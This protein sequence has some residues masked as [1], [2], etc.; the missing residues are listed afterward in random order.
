MKQYKRIYV[1][2]LMQVMGY[3]FLLNAASWAA[4][5]KVPA[6]LIEVIFVADGVKS[7]I[8]RIPVYLNQLWQGEQ[9]YFSADKSDEINSIMTTM[10]D[11]QEMVG[12]ARQVLAANL[13]REDSQAVLAWLESS[14]G[15]ALLKVEKDAASPDYEKEI[16]VFNAKVMQ[17]P[18]TDARKQ[19]IQQLQTAMRIDDIATEILYQ[20]MRLIDMSLQVINQPSL[21]D[22][23]EQDLHL[24]DKQ[25][26][27]EVLTRQT[28][29]NMY[30]TYSTVTDALLHQYLTF[31]RSEVGK[32]YYE[33]VYNAIVAAAQLPVERL[34]QQNR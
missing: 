33:V 21:D 30:F 19:L 28:L 31:A 13:T 32:K 1:S 5:P 14:M 16:K 22:L 20:M 12:K 29:E 25:N 7:R 23:H 3:L 8:E 24:K 11:K 4:A 26:L 17:T 10:L 27:R 6:H 34:V 18:L 15:R 2:K 9:A